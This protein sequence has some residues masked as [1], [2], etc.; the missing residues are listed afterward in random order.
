MLLYT[1]YLKLFIYIGYAKTGVKFFPNWN[2]DEIK[3]HLKDTFNEKLCDTDFDI[4]IPV[5]GFLNRIDDEKEDLTGDKLKRI[6]QNKMIYLKP[7]V[8][9]PCIEEESIFEGKVII[10]IF[11]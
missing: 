6:S 3:N 9:L 8:N 7:H 11:N 4:F 5:S 10:H 1:I 2:S